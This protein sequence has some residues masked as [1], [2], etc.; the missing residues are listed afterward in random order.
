MKPLIK[1]TL[2]IMSIFVHLTQINAIPPQTTDDELINLFL[3]QDTQLK[4]INNKTRDQLL[5]AVKTKNNSKYAE[6]YLKKFGLPKKSVNDQISNEIFFKLN[7]LHYAANDNVINIEKIKKLIDEH[8]NYPTQKDILG[9]TPIDIFLEKIKFIEGKKTDNLDAQLG[10]L[11]F[12]RYENIIDEQAFDTTILKL[13]QTI[14]KPVH[15][16]AI[17]KTLKFISAHGSVNL[18]NKTFTALLIQLK[19]VFVNNQDHYIGM[20]TKLYPAMKKLYHKSSLTPEDTMLPYVELNEAKAQDLQGGPTH[21]SDLPHYSYKDHKYLEYPC[22]IFSEYHTRAIRNLSFNDADKSKNYNQI[23][24]KNMFLETPLHLA[25]EFNNHQ[26]VKQLYDLDAGSNYGGENYLSKTAKAIAQEKLITDSSFQVVIDVLDGKSPVIAHEEPKPKAE[27]PE[28]KHEEPIKP[29]VHEEPKIAIDQGA[30]QAYKEII[31]AIKK[32][33]Y[34]ELKKLLPDQNDRCTK[35][36]KNPE[37]TSKYDYGQTLFYQAATQGK[38]KI[39]T[40]LINDGALIDDTAVLNAIKS[41]NYKIITILIPEKNDRLNKTFNNQKQTLL[42]LAA[43][44]GYNKIIRQLLK[45]GADPKPAIKIA[46]ENKNYQSIKALIKKMPPI[47]TMSTWYSS[48][49]HDDQRYWL[50]KNHYKD[51]KTLLHYFNESLQNIS[52][53]SDLKGFTETIKGVNALQYDALKS[54]FKKMAAL[55][56]EQ[57]IKDLAKKNALDLKIPHLVVLKNKT[58]VVNNISYVVTDG[59]STSKLLIKSVKD[60]FNADPLLYAAENG[61][62]DIAFSLYNQFKTNKTFPQTSNMLNQSALYLA[63]KNGHLETV[64]SLLELGMAYKERFIDGSYNDSPLTSAALNNH[65]NIMAYLLKIDDL[66]KW[67]ENS[68]PEEKEKYRKQCHDHRIND[69]KEWFDD[70]SEW[71][72]SPL[73]SIIFLKYIFSL[74][75]DERGK[76]YFEEKGEI[77]LNRWIVPGAFQDVINKQTDEHIKALKGQNDRA[78]QFITLPILHF[79]A[80]LGTK[81]IVE[82]LIKQGFDPNNKFSDQSNVMSLPLHCAVACRNLETVQTLITHNANKNAKIESG[83]TAYD[84]AQELLQGLGDDATEKEK[85][86]K[87]SA[88]VKPEEK[89]VAPEAKEENVESGLSLSLSTLKEKLEQLKFKLQQLSLQ[90]SELKEKLIKK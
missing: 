53:Y 25:V 77:L 13:I 74:P 5:N 2:L 50:E 40:G 11:K 12:F 49:Q 23:H 69:I 31:E 56:N 87:I 75:P 30:V 46:Q 26:A 82:L 14:Q 29:I 61:C 88:L 39:I 32:D 33:D 60:L 62:M 52:I 37:S 64:R 76:I 85:I 42:Q 6:E 81:Q 34:A 7:D 43:K 51:Y 17:G 89:I 21:W 72:N 57:E 1:I 58:P 3:N 65:Y 68:K 80:G 24:A 10:C 48:M 45:D 79:A 67:T 8:K 18:I 27:K 83:Q 59:G 84:L 47:D 71:Y 44:F 28:E 15:C 36:I 19:N 55:A 16:S 38:E 78:A 4:Q 73:K 35:K 63:A 70:K 86:E 9:R 66:S 22:K 90:L 20:C 41:D 54:V